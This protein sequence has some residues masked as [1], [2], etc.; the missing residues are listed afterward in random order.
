MNYM[1]GDLPI[2]EFVQYD[3]AMSRGESGT[4][5]ETE[6]KMGSYLGFCVRD[7]ANSAAN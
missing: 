1:E 2:E 4:H 3:L 5:P 7:Y 6:R